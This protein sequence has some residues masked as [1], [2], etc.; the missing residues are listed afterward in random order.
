MPLS[1]ADR[2][3]ILEQ[4][5]KLTAEVRQSQESV[6]AALREEAQLAVLSRMTEEQSHPP[7]A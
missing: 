5:A 4:L 7:V 6:N 3:W 1:A 2:R